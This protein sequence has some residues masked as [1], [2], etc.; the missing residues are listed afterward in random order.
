MHAAQ[1]NDLKYQEQMQCRGS[2]DMI[3]SFGQNIITVPSETTHVQVKFD[4]DQK[5]RDET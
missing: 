3:A 5:I 2:R 4:R 1:S